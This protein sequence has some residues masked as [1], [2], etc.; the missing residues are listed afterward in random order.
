MW[1]KV[2]A[3]VL[4]LAVPAAASAGPLKD[5]VEK[6]GRDL[7]TAQQ[8]ETSGRSRGRLWTSIALIGAGG[9]LATFGGLEVGE[10]ETGSPDADD[11]DGA[12]TGKDSDAWGKVML[13]GGIA[14]AAL[15]SFFLMTGRK[16]SG[17]VVSVGS[18][19]VAVRHTVR[20]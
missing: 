11:A 15:G 9:A 17:P 12:E 19:R 1:R 7:S 5:A 3:A 6:A 18:K 14:A 8:K 20:F 4:A 10:S 13:G 16:Q 2:I